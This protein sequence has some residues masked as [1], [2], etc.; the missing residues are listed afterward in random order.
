MFSNLF[1]FL[2]GKIEDY[3]PL[4]VILTMSDSGSAPKFE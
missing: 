4:D 3:R 2:N 1:V